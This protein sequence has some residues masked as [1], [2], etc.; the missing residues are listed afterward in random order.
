[1]PLELGKRY[2]RL[3]AIM[4]TIPTGYAYFRCECGNVKKIRTDGVIAGVVKSC[5]CWDLEVKTKHGHNVRSK[6]Q[7]SR[8]YRIWQG[9]IQRCFD[10]NSKDYKNYGARGILVCHRWWNFIN[11][12]QDMGE[13]PNELTIERKDNDDWYRPE[14]CR[15]A[16]YYEQ[17]QN[18]RP[19]KPRSRK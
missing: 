12:L 1:M 16:T 7:R 17:A 11:F 5:G 2:N 13:A 15:W 9:M 18:R 6:G 14:N 19:K 10:K 4:R 3:T 8:T